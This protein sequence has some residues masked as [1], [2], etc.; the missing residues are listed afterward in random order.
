M[1]KDNHQGIMMYCGGNDIAIVG[2]K[3]TNSVEFI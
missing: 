1:L 3:L 2:N